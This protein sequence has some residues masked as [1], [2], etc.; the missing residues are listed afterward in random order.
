MPSLPLQLHRTQQPVREAVAWW[1][2]GDC[3]E[4]WVRE[5]LQWSVDEN[6]LSIYVLPTSK[7]NLD[8]SGIFVVLSQG[9]PKQTP[10]GMAFGSIGAGIW[11]PVSALLSP[12]LTQQEIHSL[13]AY[14]C[15][16]A[17][18]S[19]GWFGF[20]EKDRK[21]WMDLFQ[22]PPQPTYPWNS[23]RPGERW[24]ST[25]ISIELESSSKEILSFST[26]PN[27]SGFKASEIPVEEPKVQN[28]PA[29]RV[30]KWIKKYKPSLGKKDSSLDTPQPLSSESQ[31]KRL[32]ELHRLLN[33]LEQDPEK[34]L[35]YAISL[36][37][38]TS[39][40]G[41]ARGPDAL[42]IHGTAFEEASQEKITPADPWDIPFE[43]EQKL[44]RQYQELFTQHIESKNYLQAA[45][46]Q[47]R[48]L[49]D[50]EAAVSA[51]KQGRFYQEAGEI[52]EESLNR[53]KDAAD[54]YF[55]AKHYAK[56]A[57]LYETQGLHE[58]MAECWD[59]LGE[60]STAIQA[61]H[62]AVQY[63]LSSQNTLEAA[64][65][66]EDRLDETTEALSLLEKAWNTAD[67]S[68]ANLQ[69]YLQLL[70]KHQ[71]TEQ[72]SSSLAQ[73]HILGCRPSK[74]K[75]LLDI[76]VETW[77][78][79][80]NETL[81][82]QLRS[83]LRARVSRLL[84]QSTY[85]Q[86]RDYLNY[87]IQVVPGD[88]LFI[89]DINRFLLRI[90]ENEQ[91]HE[92]AHLLSSKKMSQPLP[93]RSFP[94]SLHDVQWKTACSVQWCYYAVGFSSLVGIVAIRGNW[95]GGIQKAQWETSCPANAPIWLKP[96]IAPDGPALLHQPKRR[97]GGFSDRIFESSES[98][99][100]RETGI[101]TPDWFPESVAGFAIGHHSYWVLRWST[102]K[103]RFILSSYQRNGY[104]IANFDA[105]QWL[106]DMC[107]QLPVDHLQI[108]GNTVVI[109]VDKT[110]VSFHIRQQRWSRDNMDQ[111]VHQLNTILW[112]GTYYLFISWEVGLSMLRPDRGKWTTIDETWETP[113]TLYLPQSGLLVESADQCVWL[114]WNQG[115]FSLKTE[116]PAEEHPVLTLLPG[117]QPNEFAR[118][119]TNGSLTLLRLPTD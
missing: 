50:W 59:A 16:V 70:Q 10:C 40:R 8:P 17:H 43:I 52:L 37:S 75:L 22:P 5:I 106:S 100:F 18:P 46:I 76:L 80:G 31:N 115:Q 109:S 82:S 90:Q 25:I 53:F 14:E 83:V 2:Q 13:G 56:A 67:P 48:L 61:Y 54:C 51:L 49:G 98:F 93:V 77:H 24:N 3:L 19:L 103:H 60:N 38:S 104:I 92:P 73:L 87:L 62:K 95:E 36:S 29:E 28:S 81:R 78:R 47:A 118:F 112:K 1:L 63:H 85:T 86:A 27:A 116:Y 65:I 30:K 58:K 4:D 110:M 44:R 45:Y 117:E 94:S 114:T 88:S 105:P 74:E 91:S 11:I 69:K 35:Q 26:E 97:K 107:S 102:E 99:Y 111:K 9:T 108:C 68:L 32:K 21:S 84:P 89:R 55:L 96:P 39:F 79:E 119:C 57:R 20:E 6:A 42:P 34:G 12:S 101:G 15:L 66:L 64:R 33:L 72:M 7:H 41:F 23:A 71:M 113:K